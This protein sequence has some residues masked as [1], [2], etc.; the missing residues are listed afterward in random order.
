MI[1]NILFYFLSE[2]TKEIKQWSET[3]SNFHEKVQEKFLNL[4]EKQKSCL[5]HYFIFIIKQISNNAIETHVL[6]NALNLSIKNDDVE[7]A[8][9]VGW[10]IARNFLKYSKVHVYDIWLATLCRCP[11]LRKKHISWFCSKKVTII[12]MV[13]QL[14]E[15]IA[16][17]FEGIPIKQISYHCEISKEAQAISNERNK[18]VERGL[19]IQ[20]HVPGLLAKSFSTTIED[21]P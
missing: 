1:T 17:N 19:N 10:E 16:N 6:V 21:F 20:C 9:I 7:T 18:L 15:E 5:C 14:I 12:I 3:R 13:P 11:R 8:K 4:I 2:Y